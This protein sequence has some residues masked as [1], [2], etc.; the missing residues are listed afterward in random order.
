[1]TTSVVYTTQ[2]FT[3]TSCA[4]TVTNCPA[5]STKVVTSTIALYTVSISSSSLIDSMLT[6]LDCL[7]RLSCDYYLHDA[8]LNGGPY[9]H[10]CRLHHADLHYNLL[11]AH[12]NE[13]PGGI[14]ESRH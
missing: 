14:H 6:Q 5:E 1:M 9:D 10:F 7:P 12:S 11:R 4:S 13:L 2:T 3:V 8:K